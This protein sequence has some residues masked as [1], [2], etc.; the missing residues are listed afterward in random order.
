MPHVTS[1]TVGTRAKATTAFTSLAG[2]VLTDPTNVRGKVRAPDGQITT[3]VYGVDV[4]L[5]R[6]GTG[7]YSF[8]FTIST[9][10]RWQ[11]RCE[12]DGAVVAADEIEIVAPYSAL[13]G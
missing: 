5:V 2:G 3:Y 13:A 8:E 9:N 12:G 1:L 6:E 11:A 10:G 7:I 4:E